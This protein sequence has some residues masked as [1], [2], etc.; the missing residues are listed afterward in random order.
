MSTALGLEE[1]P[2]NAWRIDPPPFATWVRA[3][4][5]SRSSGEYLRV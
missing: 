5:L 1:T 2:L 3:S 4:V